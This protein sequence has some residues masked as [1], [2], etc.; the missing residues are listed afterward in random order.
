MLG[1]QLDLFNSNILNITLTQLLNMQKIDILFTLHFS[2]NLAFFF[3][4]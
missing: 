4:I 2:P 3:N 1:W